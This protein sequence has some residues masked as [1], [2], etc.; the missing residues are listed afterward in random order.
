MFVA[1]IRIHFMFVTLS[2]TACRG[3]SSPREAL[4]EL[5]PVAGS[6]IIGT[7]SYKQ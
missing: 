4:A 1:Y 6:I 2:R 5:G 7:P 3:Q